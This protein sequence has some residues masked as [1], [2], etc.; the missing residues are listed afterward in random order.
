MKVEL[1]YFDGCPQYL[2]AIENVREA[3]RLEGLP[4]DVTL[5]QVES[6][7]E[8]RAR[9]FIGSPTVRINGVDVEGPEAEEKGYGFGCRIYT[10][11]GSSAG[12]PSVEKVRKALSQ[13]AKPSA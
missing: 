12:W 6:D 1:Y 7:A 8:V 4:E 11:N 10:S 5:I 2:K 9:R 13:Q 3:L